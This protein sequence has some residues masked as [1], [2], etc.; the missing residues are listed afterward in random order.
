MFTLNTDADVETSIDHQATHHVHFLAGDDS[1]DDEQREA[2][3]AE[4]IQRVGKLEAAHRVSQLY[5]DDLVGFSDVLVAAA[6]HVRGDV[7]RLFSLSMRR[8]TTQLDPRAVTARMLATCAPL[9]FNA[10]R[11]Q[12]LSPL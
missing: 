3:V 5:A 8:D 7:T 1:L 9:S 11:L 2:I 10:P 4:N 6:R 12:H